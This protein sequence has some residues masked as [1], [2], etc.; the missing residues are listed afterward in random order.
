MNIGNLSIATQGPA[1]GPGLGGDGGGDMVSALSSAIS[2]AIEPLRVSLESVVSLLSQ[3]FA[4]DVKQQEI[5]EKGIEK[6]E[7]AAAEASAEGARG[8]DISGPADSGMEKIGEFD[9]LKDALKNTS[10]GIIQAALLALGAALVF[11]KDETMAIINSVALP[12]IVEGLRKALNFVAKPFRG[13]ISIFTR[14]GKFF[15]RI[16]ESIGAVVKSMAKG[17]MKFTGFIAK[18]V[19]AV[20]AIL[21]PFGAVLRALFLPVAVIMST[22]DA[23]K[24]FVAGFKDG[25]ILDGIFTAIGEVLGGL[26]GLPLDLLKKLVGF[27]AGLLGFDQFKEKLEKFS[28][29]EIIV[30]FFGNIVDFFRDAFKGIMNKIEDIIRAIPGFGD[31]VADK[32]FG[33]KTEGDEARSRIKDLEKSQKEDKLA[34]KREKA[35]A[36]GGDPEK[37]AKLESKIDSGERAIAD[38]QLI[39]EKEDLANMSPA[40]RARLERQKK[41]KETA[42]KITEAKEKAGL[43]PMAPGTTN[44]EF[45]D[46][47]PVNIVKDG[48]KVDP[49]V[50]GDILNQQ[51]AAAA[52]AAAGGT[53]NVGGSTT[54]APTT[55][56]NTNV[57]GG[58]SGQGSVN[59]NVH[60]QDPS[61]FR[62]ES[63]QAQF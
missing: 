49:K 46:G 43:D 22:I 36:G 33:E 12:K 60:P 28:F 38:N 2:S 10:S 57:S 44:I 47:K 45:K 26:V 3:I 53:T 51:S 61:S 63:A 29:K 30:D 41:Q 23:V 52:G 32:F 58:P 8:M 54:V 18:I 17:F 48:V 25:G 5:L 13:I 35:K 27:I 9:N 39:I 6:Q 40:R 34:L 50:S 55:I 14:I 24:G 31:S 19:K 7:A 21:G 20:L 62:L 16:G 15:G 11:F 1:I 59:A 4:I 42:D 37:I 56:N